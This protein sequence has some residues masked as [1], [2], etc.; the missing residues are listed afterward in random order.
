MMTTPSSL[1]QKPKLELMTSKRMY[2]SFDST[3]SHPSL[4]MSDGL[5]Y[6]LPEFLKHPVGTQFAVLREMESHLS[7][8]EIRQ[9][10]AIL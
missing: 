1:I 9:I 8:G 3:G 6:T 4:E 5:R 2:V 7:Y 10:I